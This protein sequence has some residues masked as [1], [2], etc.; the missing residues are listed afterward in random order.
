MQRLQSDAVIK[1]GTLKA[2]ELQLQTQNILY[3][4]IDI[5]ISFLQKLYWNI[6]DLQCCISFGCTESQSVIHI[7]ISIFFI[8]SFPI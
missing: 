4:M 5:K 7:H 2:L 1:L 6:V 8:F 3:I